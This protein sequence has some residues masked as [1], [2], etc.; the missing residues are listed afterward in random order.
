MRPFVVVELPVLLELSIR[1][2]EILQ[3]GVSQ[4]LPSQR[5]VEALLLALGLRVQRASVQGQHAQLHQP[6]LKVRKARALRGSPGRFVVT[7]Q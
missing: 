2:L 7:Q 3:L 1:I 4:Q 6:H 5:A